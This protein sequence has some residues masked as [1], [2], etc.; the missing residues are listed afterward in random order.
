MVKKLIK[1]SHGSYCYPWKCPQPP[2]KPY[3]TWVCELWKCW[4]IWVENKQTNKDQCYIYYFTNYSWAMEIEIDG[5]RPGKSSKSWCANGGYHVPASFL[6]SLYSFPY[7]FFHAQK[8]GTGSRGVD[9]LYM[10]QWA[11]SGKNDPLLSHNTSNSLHFVQYLSHGWRENRKL[12]KFISDAWNMV[13][14]HW[15]M[16]GKERNPHSLPWLLKFYPDSALFFGS[17]G[18]EL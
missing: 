2:C 15:R 18:E 6:Q 4:R 17:W 1:L 5:G 16:L 13:V 7:D 9:N 12:W 3:H 11:V 10:I 14:A 8:K